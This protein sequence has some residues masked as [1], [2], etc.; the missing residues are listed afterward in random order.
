MADVTEPPPTDLTP[1]AAEH[2]GYDEVV[3]AI[4]ALSPLSRAKLDRLE[5]RH[6]AGTDFAVGDLLQ[7]AICS[8]LMEKKRCP[9]TTPFIAFLAQSIR[10]IAGRQRRR[11]SRQIPVAGGATENDESYEFEIQDDK[12]RVD[13]E[14]IRAENDKRAVEVWGV[15][16]PHYRDDEQMQMVLLGWEEDMRGQ[17]LREF[18]GVEQARLDYVAKKIRRIA[19]KHFPKGWPL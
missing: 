14:I 8:A 11:L 17:E 15:L 10:N 13:E 6:L 18:V 4:D 3:A 7:E 5:L 9:R 1:V 2:L 12:P 19:A 16:E